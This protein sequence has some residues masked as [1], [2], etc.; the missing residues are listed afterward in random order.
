MRATIATS[1]AT[2][3]E[4]NEDFAAAGAN[5]AV[6]L[7]GAGLAGTTTR[8]V[9]GVAWYARHLG[10]A[11]LAGLPDE[12]LD[13]TSILARAI[14]ETAAL[15][16]DTCDLDDPGT[17]SATVVAVRACRGRLEYLVLADSVLVLDTKAGPPVVVTDDRGNRIGRRFRQEMDRTRH[18]TPEHAEARR[19]YV[20]ALRAYRNRPGGFWVA[21]ADPAAAAQAITGH[22]PLREVDRAVLLSDGAHRIVE[23]FGLATW[24]AV[25]DTLDT[26]GPAEIIRQVRRAESSDPDG[27]RWPRAKTHDDATVV[28]CTDLVDR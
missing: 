13:L 9:H 14:A 8:C 6:L 19:R 25:L 5:G 7:D 2:P 17:P 11:V 1:Q 23:P 18:G 24:R 28:Y 21:A 3:E 12:D 20:E 27:S 15:H 22:R 4:P 26:H 16:A 10:G